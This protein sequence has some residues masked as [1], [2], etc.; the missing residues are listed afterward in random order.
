MGWWDNWARRDPDYSPT[1]YTQLAAALTSAGDR[2]AAYEIRYLGRERERHEDRQQGKW[3]RWFF[4]T[5]L[6]D[7]AGYG[8]GSYLFRVLWWVIGISLAGA[9][10]LW[11]KVPAAKQHG[12]IWCFGASLARL[13]PAIEINKEFT[14]FFDDPERNRLTCWQS[15]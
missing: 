7:V 11:M 6:R 8:I 3:G 5:A 12:P 13:L 4:Q 9:A 15:G 1:P 2:D 10:L 14:A